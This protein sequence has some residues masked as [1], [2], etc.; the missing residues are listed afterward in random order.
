MEAVLRNAENGIEV[1]GDV[2]DADLDIVD[3]RIEV[4]TL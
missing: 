2:A 1:G 4:R 3:W